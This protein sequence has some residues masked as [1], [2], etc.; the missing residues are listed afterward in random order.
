MLK[1][2]GGTPTE[3]IVDIT[4]TVEKP[5]KP[6]ESCTQKVEIKI[7]KFFVVN[8]ATDRLPLQILDASR[9]VVGQEFDYQA[10][11]KEEE[12]EGDN[13]GIIKVKLKTRL[14]NRVIDLRTVAKQ[15][16]FRLSSGVCQLFREFLNQNDFI[17]IHT[18]KLIGGTSEGGANVFRL[19]YFGKEACLAQSPQLYKQMCIMADF[20][21][22]Y[23]IAPVFRAENSF[24][25]R[26]M[27]EFVGLDIEMAIKEH[28]MELLEFLGDLFSFI[29]T[30]LE[31]R[32]AKELKAINEQFEFEPF[33]NKNP[34]VKLTFEEG[35]NLLKENGIDWKVNEDLTT[36]VEKQLG[37]IGKR[38]SLIQFA[39]NTTLISTCCTDIQRRLDH[40]T[41][42]PA[43]TIQT[44]HAPTTSL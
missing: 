6:I 35:V 4:G 38:C 43:R 36:K 17:E 23:E 16:I 2:M 39:R 15:A 33:K 29:F 37:E 9:K 31:T 41:R 11:E 28:Y 1:Y 34:V 40:S 30:G 44:S 19:K 18:P 24:T 10:Q 5:E 32:Y 25:H 7:E 12:P 13:K 21:R 26:H 27:C 20:D 22:V 8:R 3:S 42:C 14:D